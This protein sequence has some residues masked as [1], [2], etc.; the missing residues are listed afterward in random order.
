MPDLIVTRGP[1]I[2]DMV[3]K[4]N[5]LK[6]QE[7]DSVLEALINEANLIK[8]H[9]PYYNT[10]EKDNKS[11]QYLGITG[12]E[13]PKILLIRGR[14]LSTPDKV[15]KNNI[16]T[17]FGPYPNGTTLREA[18]KIVRR[19]FPFVDEHSGKR[20]NYEFYRQLGLSPDTKN[21]E[22]RKQYLENISNI[23]LIFQGKKKTLIRKLKKEMTVFAKEQNFEKA[24]LIKKKVFALEHINDVA[25]IKD[26][27]LKNPWNGRQR[28]ESYDVAH[29][30]GKSMV[31]VM[32]TVLDGTISKDDYRKFIIRSVDG[33]NDTGALYEILTRRLK[34]PQWGMPDIIVVDG[35]T[36][37]INFANKALK[38]SGMTIP[39]VAVTKD[40]RHKA[41]ELRGDREIIEKHRNSILLANSE[42]H[43]FAIT[44]HKKRRGKDFLGK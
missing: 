41:R 29:L 3:T 10:K 42:S 21:S 32:T 15:K 16:K 25:L 6:W 43:R 9:W 44:F 26:E 22:L 23:K 27:N 7:N 35:S 20:D 11:F 34:H 30:S 24:D 12:D 31:G 5:G 2:L 14:A 17:L 37:Q 39:I 36:A 18:L 38:D 13:F 1:L 19:I 33:S 40:E 28:I 8:K 4:S